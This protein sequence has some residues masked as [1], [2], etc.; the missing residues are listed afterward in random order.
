MRYPGSTLFAVSN[1]MTVGWTAP[2]IPYLISEKSHIK[3]TKQKAEQLESALLIG[4]FCGLPTTIFFTQKIGRKR[5]LLLA[6]L[7]VLI[8][9]IAIAL[10]D[11]LIYIYVARFFSGMAGNMAFVA[12]PMYIAEIAA[13]KIRGFLSSI[14]YLMMLTGCLIIY[15]VGP[16]FPY[17]TS[18]IIGGCLAISEL[19]IFSFM[20][21][22]PYYL[23]YKNRPEEAK[24]S[25]Q[26]FRPNANTEKEIKD[27]SDAITRQKSERGRIKDLFCS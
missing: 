7:V 23:L 11:S 15:C 3:T 14:I 6:S 12:A 17:Y 20:P 24:R 5:S 22:S 13:Q 27:I 4:A 9:W 26:Y 21:E 25:L 16:Y 10:G 18:S 2:M 8:A 19:A 1:G